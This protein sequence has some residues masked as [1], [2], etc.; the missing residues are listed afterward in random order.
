MAVFPAAGNTPVDS[1]IPEVWASELM[2]PLQ[3]NLVLGSGVCINRDFEGEIKGPGDQVHIDSL[4]R[5]TIVDYS[6]NVDVVPQLLET[7]DQLLAIDHGKAFAFILDDLDRV[8]AAGDM[9]I[10]ATMESVQALRVAA[11]TYVGTKMLAGALAANKKVFKTTGATLGDPFIALVDY[12]VILDNDDVPAARR[13]AVVRP[14]V[15]AMILKH[16]KFIASSYGSGVPIQ[17]GVIGSLAGFT[18]AVTPHLPANVNMIVGSPIATT[19]GDQIVNVESFRSPTKFGYV[20]R[21]LHVAGARVIRPG[22]LIIA[23]ES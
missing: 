1:F 12:G 16:D 21:G 20:V 4:T 18:V 17:N 10:T 3:E 19:F 9:I 14:E 15:K 2:V 7:E 22:A 23:S 5:P 13:F 11:D 6:R 8:Q